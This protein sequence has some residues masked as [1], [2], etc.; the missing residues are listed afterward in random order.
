MVGDGDGHAKVSAGKGL[1]VVVYHG[2]E[3]SGIK[4]KDLKNVDVRSTL[5]GERGRLYG[6][7]ANSRARGYRQSSDLHPKP[8][9]QP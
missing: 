5:G 2:K 9:G 4:P 8:T 1:S 3:R 6:P 7:R